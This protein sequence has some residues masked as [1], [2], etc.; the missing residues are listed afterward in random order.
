MPTK[1]RLQRH[2]R[3]ARP[4]FAIVVADSRAKRDGKFITKLGQ[5]NPNTNPATIELNFDG[6]VDWMMKGAQPTNTVRAILSHEGVL[7]K[8]HLLAGAAKGAFSEEEAE[9]RFEAWLDQKNTKTQAKTE[10][11]LKLEKDI[12]AAA[13]KAE[14]DVNDARALEI[15]KANSE[16]VAEEAPVTEEAPAAEEAPVAEEAPAAEEAPVAEEAPAAEEAPVA[17]EAP[18]AESKEETK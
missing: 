1:I 10:D 8:K 9:T 7:M 15:A 12:L 17:E 11:I 2:G 6:A 16:L 18:A 14:K 4:I 3:K 5:Y 13:L